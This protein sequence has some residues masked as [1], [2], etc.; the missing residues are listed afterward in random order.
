MIG[1]RSLF[2]EFV[3][4]AKPK[5]ASSRPSA[6]P[7]GLADRFRASRQLTEELASVLSVEDQ[8]VQSMPDVSPT[9]WHRAHTT[10]FYETFVLGHPEVGQVPRDPAYSY[11]FNSYYEAVGERHP[12]PTRGL[13]TRPGVAEIGRYRAEVDESM[14]PVVDEATDDPDHPLRALIELG[15]NHEQQHQELLLMDIKHV[16]SL[17][18]MDTA[19]FPVGAAGASVGPVDGTW[20]DPGPMGWV[21]GPD[22]VV[23]VGVA[24][25]AT[26]GG[27]GFHFDNE[28][29][30]HQVFLPPHRLADR[31]VTC[32]EWLEFMA[33]GGYEEPRLWL[34][35][36]WFR[37]QAEGWEAPLYWRRD[38]EGWVQH[39]M[40]G[41]RPV[42]PA[43]PV[44]HV[45]F[46]EADAF[47]AWTGYRLPTEFEWEVA[48]SGADPA[49]PEAN[50]LWWAG[51]GG[52]SVHDR[53]PFHPR[54]APPVDGSLRQL[55]GDCWEWTASPHRPYPSF[56]AAEGAVGEYN[57]KFMINTMVLRGGCAFTP[58]GHVRGT[59]RNFF[60]PHTR[61]HL[62]GV[63]LA[64]DES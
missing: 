39:T 20:P 36:G 57:G 4:T 52:E 7:A 5:S 17:G 27:E 14:A 21:P 22:G 31:L 32:G 64:Q 8:T 43:E 61:W 33:D 29:P 48:A 34:S 30:H 62:S 26:A 13:V 49:D 6:T 40:A 37:R 50:L 53:N 25:A 63:R 56:R 59:Y 51:D 47:A 2:Y 11:L 35:D 55:F 9:K 3:T 44:C 15:I 12:R 38:G 16:L 24:G 45:S 58:A 41:T 60:H 18:F 19:Y 10:W 54:L 23:G 42:D 46:Y 28:G 1:F